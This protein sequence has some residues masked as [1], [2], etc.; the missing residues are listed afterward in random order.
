LSLSA[1]ANPSEP[2][3]LLRYLDVALVA[4]AAPI[5]VLIGVPAVGYLAGAG[6]WVALR[7]LGILVERAAHGAQFRSEISIRLGYLLGRLFV[8]ALAVIL[9]RRGE[10]RDAGLAALLV[11]VFAFTVQLA[12]SAMTRPRRQ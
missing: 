6:A 7:A 10:G 9:I 3:L 2:V 5:M 8:L 4:L 12:C 1:S 11:I